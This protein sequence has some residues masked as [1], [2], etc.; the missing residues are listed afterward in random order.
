MNDE[1]LISLELAL[2][3]W[4]AFI[5]GYEWRKHVEKKVK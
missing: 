4:G 3:V 5:V 2:M 1:W